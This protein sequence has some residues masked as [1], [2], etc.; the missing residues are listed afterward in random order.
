MRL[1]KDA[2]G[3]ILPATIFLGLGVSY[4]SFT[5]LQFTASTNTELTNQSFEIIAEEA[6]RAGVDYLTGCL[7]SG[8]PVAGAGGWSTPHTPDMSCDESQ[9]NP[10]GTSSNVSA[11]STPGEW[12]STFSVSTPTSAGA[13]GSSY[14]RAVSTG[15]VEVFQAG[16]KVK[17]VYAT[18]VSNF[19]VTTELRRTSTGQSITAVRG[20]EN[21]CAIANGKLYCWG[22]NGSGQLGVGDTANRLTPTLV[23]PNPGDPLYGKVVT[24]VNMSDATTCAIANGEPYC[25]GSN[26][27]QQIGDGTS[28]QRTIP[29]RV[30][31]PLATSY[32]TE[33]STAAFNMP[34]VWLV[35]P[36]AANRHSCAISNGVVYCWGSNE[37]RQLTGGSCFG[38]WW[39]FGILTCN[40]PNQAF[41]TAI[42]GYNSGE[43]DS[44]MYQRK[45]ER[46]TS[47]S[48]AGCAVTRGELNCWGVAAPLRGTCTFYFAPAPF[49]SECANHYENY[50]STDY[51]SRII[52][53]QTW[54]GSTDLGC[55]MANFDFLCFGKTPALSFLWGSAFNEPTSIPTGLTPPDVTDNDNG[56]ISTIPAGLIGNFCVVDSGVGKCTGNQPGTA[57]GSG[58]QPL[59]TTATLP[60]IGLMNRVPTMIAAGG[61]YGCTAANGQLFCWGQGATGNLADGG[62]GNIATPKLTG[63]TGLTPI[64]TTEELVGSKRYAA[65]GPISV[66]GEHACASINGDL[67]CWGRNDEG[68]LGMGDNNTILQPTTPPSAVGQV[69]T[70]VSSGEDHTCAI[71]KGRLYCWGDNDNGQLGIGNN[72]DTNTPQQVCPTSASPGCSTTLYNKRVTDVSAG[73]NSTCAVADGRVYCWGSNINGMLGTTGINASYNTP[74]LA[75]G[76][77]NILNGKVATAISVGVNH[78]CAIVN[79]DGYC[80]GSNSDGQIGKSTCVGQC[81]PTRITDRSPAIPAA[82]NLDTAGVYT[83]ISVGDSYSCAIINSTVSCWGRSDRGQTG[84]GTTA[85]RTLPT[86]VN[87]TYATAISAGRHH[88]CAVLNGDTHCWGERDNGRLGAI[89]GA[90]QLTPVAATGGAFTDSDGKNVAI[91]VSAGGNT[92]CSVA[93]AKIICWGNSAFG[94]TGNLGAPTDVTSP[95]KTSDYIYQLPY[96]KGPIY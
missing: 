40:F 75:N 67:Y 57:G 89:Y 50:Y 55:T 60:N 73:D 71:S 34:F 92:S 18:K 84:T 79:A 96:Y 74:Q 7:Q 68:Q 47:A 37:Y 16:T 8:A 43:S 29:T 32:V 49:P 11:S 10:P 31:G 1:R 27:N 81:G 41:P 66:G 63:T 93:N 80:W 13:L 38:G 17:T 65:N 83:A 14:Y 24:Q 53:A 25:W 62:T 86:Q 23:S 44:L 42:Y 15:K 58:L 28:T 51:G 48:H 39:T 2:G 35:P 54:Q 5:F 12:R 30:L 72:T 85:D 52:D 64:G 45:A 82:N 3:Y 77:G 9:P 46:V 94:Q 6:A 95:L 70:K 88:A 61:F 78:V 20:D 21:A 36:I 26:G 56:E 22:R 69:I 91:N 90:D 19:R 76:N 33:V 59:V 87:T 4:M